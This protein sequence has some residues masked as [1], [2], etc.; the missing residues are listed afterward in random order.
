V[1]DAD[2]ELASDEGCE[3]LAVRQLVASSIV[4]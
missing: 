1:W 2:V 3:G 4:A